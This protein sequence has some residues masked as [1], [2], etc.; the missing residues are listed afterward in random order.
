MEEVW[1]MLSH[2]YGRPHE[3]VT[4]SICSQTDFQLS[5]KREEEKL[6]K[7]FEIGQRLLMT[8]KRYGW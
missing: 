4:E 5:F 1:D 8:W 2:E 7:F 3:L 6:S